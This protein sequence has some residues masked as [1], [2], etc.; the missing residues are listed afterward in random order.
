MTAGRIG[1]GPAPGKDWA[2]ALGPCI[3]TR[4]EL[5]ELRDQSVAVRV[6]GEERSRG[7]Y[8]ELVHRNPLVKGGER[9]LWSFPE[10][11]QHLSHAQTIHAGEVW[12]SGTIPGG[13]ELERG[14]KARY[15][16]PGDRVE[17]EIE[18]IGVLANSIGQT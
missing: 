17:I 9:P 2:N 13:C 3:V 8:D 5:G 15:L 10:M 11:L 16:N 1:M 4:D 7:R 6:N 14:D 12:G 18:G